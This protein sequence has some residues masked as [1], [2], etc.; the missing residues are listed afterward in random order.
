MSNEEENPF[1]EEPTFSTTSSATRQSP[2]T[3]S[4]EALPTSSPPPPDD[5]SPFA[6]PLPDE[7]DAGL[8]AGSI[9]YPFSSDDL[10]PQDEPPAFVQVTS[11]PLPQLPA[12]A[13][14]EGEQEGGRGGSAGQK[15]EQNKVYER[16]ARDA[17][18]VRTSPPFR[19]SMCGFGRSRAS[20]GAHDE[21]R[22]WQRALCG[23]TG[24]S[25]TW[26]E[27][28]RANVGGLV[29]D[30]SQLC[31]RSRSNDTDEVTYRLLTL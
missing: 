13:H 29:V 11:P 28:L 31:S 18:Q 27:S 1:T 3:Q 16:P 12:D 4:S 21:C 17:I 24:W 10:Y 15:Q 6:V 22:M 5:P 9:A 19:N 2:S 25:G 26:L 8:L 14:D 23:I 30:S 7:D 20:R